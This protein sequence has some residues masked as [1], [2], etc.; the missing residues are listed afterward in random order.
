MHFQNKSPAS[1]THQ[2]NRKNSN[3]KYRK[4]QLLI[5]FCGITW[6][7]RLEMHAEVTLK[8]D[9]DFMS[10]KSSQNKEVL[11]SHQLFPILKTV[12]V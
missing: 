2:P 6:T 3:A 11:V 8:V 12:N 7:T 10:T 5:C 9:Y 4:G 1:D